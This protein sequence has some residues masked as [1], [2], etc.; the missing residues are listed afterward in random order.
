MGEVVDMAARRDTKGMFA[1]E[2]EEMM[3]TL[4]LSRVR[5]ADLCWQCDVERRVFYYHFRDKYDLVAWMFERDYR[6]AANGAAPYSQELYAETHR[7]LWSRREFYNRAF[8]DDS[9]NSIEH[10][11]VQFSVQASEEA[12]KRHQGV[13]TLSSEMAFMARHFAYGNVGCLVEWLGGG[14][15]ATP[16][17][18][19]SYMFACMPSDLRDA[20]AERANA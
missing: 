7:T 8:Q 6:S 3:E 17:Q 13:K 2:L 15:E 10:Y 4:P 1:A 9:Q 14:F 20:H 12:L 5:V 18:L 19:A 16:E 11:I